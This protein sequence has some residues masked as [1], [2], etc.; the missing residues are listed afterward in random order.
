M[1]SRLASR[2]NY[3]LLYR[4]VRK[5]NLFRVERI[6]EFEFVS[7]VIYDNLK[8]IVQIVL[9]RGDR[10]FT[11]NWSDEL[12]QNKDMRRAVADRLATDKQF[13][14]QAWRIGHIL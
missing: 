14:I 8:N 9:Q 6:D 13:S 11:V 3:D 12:M 4:I 10:N 1:K 5:P 7:R 2:L